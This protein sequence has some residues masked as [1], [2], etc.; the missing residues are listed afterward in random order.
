MHFFRHTRV[1]LYPLL[2]RGDGRELVVGWVGRSGRVIKAMCGKRQTG[3]HHS[4]AFG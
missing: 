1:S 4:L 3:R 2:L